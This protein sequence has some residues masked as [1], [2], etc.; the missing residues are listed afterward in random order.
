VKSHPLNA[1]GRRK[2]E[3]AIRNGWQPGLPPSDFYRRKKR[4]TSRQ[5]AAG[6]GF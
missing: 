6:Y 3:R 5:G 2:I 1:S 4:R